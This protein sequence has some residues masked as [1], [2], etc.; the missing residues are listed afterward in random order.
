MTAICRK[1]QFD[2]K[3]LRSITIP[4][5]EIGENIDIN[6]AE[7]FNIIKL[8]YKNYKNKGTLHRFKHYDKR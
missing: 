3:L 6:S 5:H 8:F 7:F 2:E 1:I 4:I